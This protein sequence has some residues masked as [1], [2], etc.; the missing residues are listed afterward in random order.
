MLARWEVF[1]WPQTSSVFFLSIV[2]AMGL[3]PVG[4]TTVEQLK[5]KLDHLHA[6]RLLPRFALQGLELT[7]PL[8]PRG[9]RALERV[10]ASLP[11]REYLPARSQAWE[12]A[13]G[14]F[15]GLKATAK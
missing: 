12:D 10:A 15:N 13:A 8:E 3:R 5:A 11:P 2:A 1:H 9:E 4:F 14:R 6:R 7:P